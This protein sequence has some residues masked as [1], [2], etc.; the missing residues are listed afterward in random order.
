MEKLLE[1]KVIP[2]INENDTVSISELQEDKTKSFGD[3]DKLSALVASK[4]GADLLV[5]FTNVDGIYTENPL[6]NPDA[7]LIP[8]IEGIDQLKTV[9]TNGKSTYGRGGMTSKVEAARIAA[10]SGVHTLIVSGQREN[11][12]LDIFNNQNP[13]GTLILSRNA[14][15]GR[16]RWLGLASGYNGV[17]V[18]NEGAKTALIERHASLLPSGILDVQGDFQ[19]RQ[20]VSIQD[21][22]GTEL[23]RG[24]INFSAEDTRRIQ[25]RQSREIAQLLE[26]AGT[27]V[28]IQRDNLVIYQ[29]YQI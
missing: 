8:L 20:V 19:P 10:I 22:G 16:K 6:V 4:L 11:I 25:G 18:V 15:P 3:N 23:G 21:E 2:V 9:V 27:D 12:L 29:E 13:P 17:I 7:Q 1:M 5:I 14:L 24:L 28:V 26:N